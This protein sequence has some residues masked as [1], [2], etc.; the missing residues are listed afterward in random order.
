[1]AI[2]AQTLKFGA[3]FILAMAAATAASAE[4]RFENSSGG[5][6]LLYGQ[7]DPAFQ[8]FDDGVSSTST[9]VDNVHSNSRVGLLYT[10]PMG[11]SV[12]TFHF[13]TALGLR[14]S[15]GVTQ[16]FTPDASHF[17]RT[18]LRK[19]DFSLKTQTY[20]TFSIG[21]GSMATDGVAETDL[22]GTTLVNYV[23]V[24]D[25][26]AAFRFRTSAGALSTKTIAGSFSDFDGGRRGRIRYDTPTFNGFTASISYGEE[27]VSKTADFTAAGIAL[28]YSGNFGD[29][30]IKAAVGYSEA[31]LA[32]G[33][34]LNDTIGSVSVLHASGFNVT[35]AAG[36]RK[37]SGSYQYA[38][39]GY[40]GDW[41][42]FGGTAVSVDFYR[43]NDRS[44]AGAKS[45]SY[46]LGLVQSFD[47]ARIEGYLGLTNYKL[48]EVGTSY[49][50]ASSVLFGMR[51]KF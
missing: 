44:S 32:A 47:D 36:N 50:E 3:G 12:F 24:P 19:V 29:Y 16:G 49:L 27:I 33:A 22:S 39:L 23:S 20:G 38:K 8:I 6:T 15:S 4:F 40:R 26:A 37:Q 7:I 5:N 21:Q 51:W 42:R 1:M 17:R 13:E 11:T 48:S 43:G 31:K 30:K 35:F 18:N 25:T 28:R 41:V 34:R 10:Q 2:R 14:P 9:L 46:S 45:T